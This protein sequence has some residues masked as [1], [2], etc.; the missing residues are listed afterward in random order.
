MAL[1]IPLS[2]RLYIAIRRAVLRLQMT[3]LELR[4]KLT[5]DEA[6]HLAHA[7]RTW[8]PV[9]LAH[10]RSAVADDQVQLEQLR[11]QLRRL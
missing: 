1:D 8:A 9:Q 5:T 4:I 3:R 2:K 11:A 7:L 10:Y 6:D